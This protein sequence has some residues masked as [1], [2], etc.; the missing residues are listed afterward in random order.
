MRNLHRFRYLLLLIAFSLCSARAHGSAPPTEPI[1]RLQ[2]VMHTAAIRR[3]AVDSAN[4]LLATASDDK[5]LRLWD[6]K[7]GHP[8]KTLRVPVG[9]GHEGQLLA[10]ALSPDGQT[11]AAGGDTGWHW[12]GAGSIYLFDTSSGRLTQ[13]IG[14]LDNIIS[15][16]AYSPDGDYLAVVLLAGGLRVF[17]TQD[18][19][20]VAEDREYGEQSYGVHFSRDGRLVTTCYDGFLRLYDQRFH[21]IAVQ[22]APGGHQPYQARFS[23]DG[24]WI[25]VGFHDST[26]VNVLS[27]QDLT[28]HATPDSSGVTNGN[29]I[30]VSWSADGR[31]LYAGGKWYQRV[32]GE[33]RVIRKWSVTRRGKFRRGRYVN[34]AVSA[35]NLITDF[36]PR[37]E[38]G[39]FFGAFDPAFGA[40]D[41]ADRQVWHRTPDMAD[42]RGNG[43][44][45]RLSQT[46]ET[47]RFGYVQWGKRPALFSVSRLQLEGDTAH[48]TPLDPPRLHATGL[49]ITGWE[50]TR[51][52]RLNGQPLPLERY[53]RSRSLAITPDETRFLLGTTWHLRLFDRH[54]AP[55]WTTRVPGVAW[56]VN[57][58]GDGRVAVAAC[59]DG[60][61]RWYRM[62]DGRP[63]LTFFPH[64]DGLRWV[65]WTPAGHY[66]ASVGGEELIGWHINNGKDAAADF[67]AV[68]RFRER[69][70]RPE[71]L[72]RV[73]QTVDGGE[74]Q[75]LGDRE[76]RDQLPLVVIPQALPPVV[77]LW[78]SE[79]PPSK[80]GETLFYY[81]LQSATESPVTV[82]QVKLNGRPLDSDAHNPLPQKWANQ[83]RYSLR[84]H[85]PPQAYTLSLVAKN[86]HGASEAATV[87]LWSTALMA[88]G[89]PLSMKR[90][91]PSKPSAKPQLVGLFIGVSEYQ[92]AN[93]TQLPYAA[94][95]AR[96]VHDLLAKVAQSG[97]L[98]RD[99]RLKLLLNA[100][101][102][103]VLEGLVWLENQ[104][105]PG[106]VALLFLAG[107]GVLDTD[108]RRDSFYFL[109]RDAQATS[110]RTSAIAY[111]DLKHTLARLK[112]MSF[113]FL[114]SCHA[115]GVDIGDLIYLANDL[116]SAENGV[117]VFAASTGKQLSFENAQWQ[118]GAF[119]ES[120]LEGLTGQADFRRKG[121]V[122]YKG[123]DYYL[124]DRVKELTQGKQ[125]PATAIPKAIPDF[126]LVST[127]WKEQS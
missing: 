54:G 40:V 97:G 90:R 60:T 41:R 24:R 105:Q 122:T 117:V 94:K 110:L 53:E 46:G 96:D 120:L 11:V 115:G 124:S 95:D 87:E 35:D 30:A 58:S 107:H 33:E 28:L 69:F 12:D 55:L 45:F 114:D 22:R 102:T 2:N 1:L 71:L 84:V 86:R 101:R 127:G 25:A 82:L 31:S 59:A 68:G 39:V 56:A 85:L 57:I 64:R 91:V 72:A 109:P 80:A 52:P 43:Q 89:R 4:R 3:I 34:V 121:V 29:L 50:N 37:Q 92:D 126:V 61:I 17:R 51:S 123:L 20:L 27:G 48:V 15:H 8:L 93:V 81:E 119:T 73:L 99:I 79:A 66:A 14:R 67:F 88:R 10:V 113:L 104:T 76:P 116:S 23:P 77:K 21:R 112:G 36:Q 7:T 42:F 106:D 100:T 44:G 5:T 111:Y 26:Q 49:E 19:T 13:R 65:L 103:E 75:S 32:V 62:S 47:I 70:Y 98:Y 83:Q 74:A 118:N 63:L 18:G 6:A 125:T 16:L 9:P 78:R 108:L 38:G